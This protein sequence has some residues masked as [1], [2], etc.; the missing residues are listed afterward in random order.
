MIQKYRLWDKLNEEMHEVH[1]ID[2]YE[3]VIR[4]YKDDMATNTQEI[5]EFDMADDKDTF[6][7]MPL[8]NLKDMYGDDVYAHD[9]IWDDHDDEFGVVKYDEVDAEFIIEWETHK[10]SLSERIDILEVFG[11]IHEHSYLLEN[12]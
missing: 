3:N 8:M 7:I 4:C 2:F 12:N 11:N 10:E 6:I 9:I 1:M 5:Y